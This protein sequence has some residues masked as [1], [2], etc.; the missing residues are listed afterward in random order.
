MRRE[1][2]G[3]NGRSNRSR[4]STATLPSKRF[5]VSSS[6]LNRGIGVVGGGEKI[7][8]VIG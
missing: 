4:R 2:T 7:V 5:R 6:L 8:I 1:P 3:R